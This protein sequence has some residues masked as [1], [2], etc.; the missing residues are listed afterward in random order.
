M[1]LY[2]RGGK[3]A[4]D[5]VVAGPLLLISLPV[6]AVVAVVV[7]LK[8]GA[9]VLFRQ[10]RPGREGR[11]FQIVK[12]RTMTEA[13]D[14]QGRLLPDADRLT[15]FGAFLRSTSADE[16]PEL[17]NVFRGDMSLVG[18][19]PLRMAYLDRYTREQAR[20]HEVRTG[21]TGW[22]QVN[23]RNN[24]PW[25]ERLA[26]DVWYVDNYSMSMDMKILLRTAGSVLKRSDISE[27]G[28]VT[29]QEFLGSE[30]TA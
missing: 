13:M 3:R 4:F 26:M 11:P 10:T 21:I 6:L 20:R 16:I 28:H 29:A 23:G 5:L 9:P 22:A 25:A 14:Q 2:R 15:R 1:S 7:R 17:W 19:R 8:L 27:D 12:F 30:S 18:P 24:A